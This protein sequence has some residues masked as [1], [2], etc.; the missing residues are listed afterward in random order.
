MGAVRET[1]TPV[2][3]SVYVER[4]YASQPE[5]AAVLKPV[6]AAQ[7]A[8][9]STPLSERAKILNKGVV[10]VFLTKKDVGGRGDH[11]P[12]GSPHLPESG[13][14]RGFEERARY[15][16][17]LAPEALA[18]I[19]AK[20]KPG[21]TR[22]IRREPLGVVFIVAPW[23]YPYLTSVNGV[24]PAL[25]ARQRRCAEAFCPD[26]ALRR[27]LPGGLR[28]GRPAQGPVPASGADPRG[29]RQGDR[30]TGSRL[31]VNFTGSVAGGHARCSRRRSAS[32]WA[33][34]WS[35]AAKTRPMSG[36]TPTSPMRSKTWS[37]ARCSIP[38]SAAAP[39]E[40]IYVH[41]SL[42]DKF[43]DGFVDLTKKYKLGNPADPKTNLGPMVRTAAGVRPWADRRRG[44]AGARHWSIRN[45][46]RPTNRGRHTSPPRYW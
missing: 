40:R 11:P 35:S 45:C 14:M 20:D 33:W 17:Q 15:M 37:T 12:D 28:P 10:D 36:P 23:N 27:A 41:E 18:D 34:G 25:M 8:W 31:C 26:P 21:F 9:K 6:V 16:I 5:I 22:F 46:S 7:R 13:E 32:S 30:R 4:P 42:Y 38:A 39:S 43:V 44:E 1:I 2:D 29:Y 24:I 3:N 19:E